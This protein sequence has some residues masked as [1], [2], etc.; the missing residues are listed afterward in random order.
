M[1]E[2]SFESHR[3]DSPGGAGGHQ[4]LIIQFGAEIARMHIRR[5]L[6]RVFVVTQNA[7]DE[8]VQSKFL[9]ARYFKQA[10]HRW[11]DHEVSE[12]GDDIAREDRL[13][14][15][16]RHTNDLPVTERVGGAAHEFKEL[17]RAQNRVWNSGS[18]D[19]AFLRYL[20]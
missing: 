4:R 17:G 7:A 12:G 6:A 18:L 5:H 8:L 10:I 2:P 13:Y 1:G 16:R 11:T 3:A 19:K 15:G 20:C 9:G 14:Q